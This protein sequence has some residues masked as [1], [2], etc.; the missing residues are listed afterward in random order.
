VPITPD[1][2]GPRFFAV[3]NKRRYATPLLLVLVSIELMDLVFAV[4]SI[5]AVFA[6]TR[7]AFIVFSSNVFAIL[8]LRSLYFLLSGVMERFRYLK[9]GLSVVLVFVGLKM[10]VPMWGIHVRS[11]VSLGIIVTVLAISMVGGGKPPKQ[12]TPGKPGAI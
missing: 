12:V 6:V 10:L 9:I 2:H 3:V 8:G 7:D 1:Y 4:D 5:P 11:D